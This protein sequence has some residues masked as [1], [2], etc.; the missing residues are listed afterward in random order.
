MKRI[1]PLIVLS[2][3]LWLIIGC[4][5][6]DN[7]EYQCSSGDANIIGARCADGTR[8]SATGQGACSSHGGVDYWI[9][10]D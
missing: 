7:N 3:L 6:S 2:A 1:L 4:E 8:S 5:K 10:E 9:C